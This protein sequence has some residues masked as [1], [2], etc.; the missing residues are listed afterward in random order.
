M[1]SSKV[2]AL[3]WKPVV[4][5]DDGIEKTSKL[6]L[7]YSDPLACQIISVRN[8]EVSHVATSHI[9]EYPLSL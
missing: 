2:E 3:G 4:H 5:W 7:S 6:I 1:D 9:V 8:L